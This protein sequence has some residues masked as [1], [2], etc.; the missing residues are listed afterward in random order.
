M[1]VTSKWE[2]LTPR[3]IGHRGAS[4][5]APE[6]TLSAFK[7]ALELN[8]DAI[9]LDVKLLKD[10]NVIVLHDK[11]LNRTTNGTGSVYDFTYQELRSLNAGSYFSTEYQNEYI[12]TLE[13]V[14][15]EIGCELLINVELTNYHRPWD[16]LARA[17]IALI[18]EF[19]LEDT[20]LLSSF[21]PWALIQAK[22]IDPT[23]ARAF[24]VGPGL[25]GWLRGLLKSFVDCDIYHPQH[26]LINKN[27][28]L[29]LLQDYRHVNV[30]TVN[31]R[32]R[33]QEL[34]SLG[35]SGIITNY[36]DI[37]LNVWKEL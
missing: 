35:V 4:A 19:E 17:T 37:A 10:G 8:A 33:M 13:E 25:P 2:I 27:S 34:V 11:A 22:R 7:M 21:N 1:S 36:P 16:G 5:Y 6:N 23:I 32:Q 28:I 31:E 18:Q 14:F 9:E 30:W 12:P 20:I 3:V 24:L 29:K 26:S 15:T